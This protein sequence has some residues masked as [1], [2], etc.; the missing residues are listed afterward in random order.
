M[1]ILLTKGLLA[2]IG[3]SVAFENMSMKASSQNALGGTMNTF[4]NRF[5]LDMM[6]VMSMISA[7]G[8]L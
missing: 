1:R 6:R 5:S 8:S 3:S 4:S 7:G 2:L